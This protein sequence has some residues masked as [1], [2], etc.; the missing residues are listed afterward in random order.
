MRLTVTG[1]GIGVLASLAFTRLISNLLFGVHATDPLTFA[2]AAL[3]LVGAS[4]LACYLPARR[5]IRIDPIAAL[6]EE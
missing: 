6:R 5:A 2:V 3:V 1:V 4:L